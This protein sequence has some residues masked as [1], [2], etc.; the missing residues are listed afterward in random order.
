MKRYRKLVG[1]YLV[2]SPIL[3]NEQLFFAAEK[4]LDGGVDILQLSAEKYTEEMYSLA[5]KLS[6]VA[7][8]RGIP[9]LIN[10]S[11]EL[12]KEVK[13][14]GVHL[15][16]FDV[17][18]A[19]VRRLLG[20]ESIVGYTVN[21]DTGK[22]KWAQQA[23]ADYVSF[24]SIFHQCTGAKCPIV[25]LGT[26]KNVTSAASLSVFAAGGITLE[27]VLLVLEAGV[28]GIAVTSVLLKSKDPHQ[29]AKSFKQIIARYG[30]KG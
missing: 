4:A 8:K 22:V 15:D 11:L 26:V 16:T 27:N 17:S 30:K 5:G 18:P 25:S 21:V 19:E 9:F 20:S 23:G 28:D 7:R 10:N 3:P 29:T 12:A 13:A 1:L 6:N 14:D 2:V 24:C